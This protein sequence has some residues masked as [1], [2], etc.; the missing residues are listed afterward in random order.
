MKEGLTI[1][2]ASG[3]V[4]LAA[5]ARVSGINRELFTRDI[6]YILGPRINAAGRLS[7]ARK[8]FDL[9]ITEDEAKALALARELNEL[10]RCRQM[11]EQQVLSEALG[12]LES[13]PP[14]ENVVV[15]QGANWHTG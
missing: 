9:L 1:L 7:D 4:G 11:E 2:N 8:A 15:V 12:Q 6:G 3:R 14:L 10:N 5:L 13:A